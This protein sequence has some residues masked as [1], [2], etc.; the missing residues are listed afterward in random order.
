MGHLG[1]CFDLEGG[2]MV[3]NSPGR[4]SCAPLLVGHSS[5]D[6]RMARWGVSAD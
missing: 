2:C 6:K 5:Q 3:Q 1:P 4:D